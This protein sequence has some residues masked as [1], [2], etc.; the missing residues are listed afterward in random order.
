MFSKLYE[1][2]EKKALEAGISKDRAAEIHKEILKTSIRR[3]KSVPC[4]TDNLEKD[5]IKIGV[6]NGMDKKGA[7]AMAK[8]FI[9]HK[10][11]RIGV[12]GWIAEMDTDERM[13]W[14]DDQTARY[15]EIYAKSSDVDNAETTYASLFPD[16][17]SILYL[18]RSQEKLHKK[19]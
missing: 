7:E 11:T 17:V 10:V 4:L 6:E 1:H 5:A 12:E 8:S 16:E 13:S 3:M 14:F 15:A 2:F 9:N 19:V 18:K